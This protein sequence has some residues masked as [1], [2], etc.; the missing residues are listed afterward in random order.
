LFSKIISE[1]LRDW[2]DELPMVAAVYNA[3][4]HEA[5]GYSPYYLVYGREYRTPLDLTLSTAN[6]SYG[7]T[8]VDYVEPE[9]KSCHRPYENTIRF[10][11]EGYSAGTRRL[12]SVLLP[13]TSS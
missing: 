3:A 10:Q 5:T 11:S 9:I 8:A 13:T 7:E 6:V 2:Q 12:G 1:N 4:K